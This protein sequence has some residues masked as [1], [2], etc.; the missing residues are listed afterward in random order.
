MEFV[1]N[2]GIYFHSQKKLAAF[3]H[4]KEISSYAKTEVELAYALGI[5]S[6][7]EVAKESEFR[8]HEHATRAQTAKMLYLMLQ[9]G[10]EF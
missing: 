8:P 6:G 2:L 4:G 7:Y 9:E 3:K 5:I 1:H 10:N